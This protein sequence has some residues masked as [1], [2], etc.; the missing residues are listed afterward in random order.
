MPKE[1]SPYPSLLVGF[2]QQE[3]SGR[4]AAVGDGDLAGT[5]PCR[6]LLLAQR[7]NRKSILHTPKWPHGRGQRRSSEQM[8]PRGL[9]CLA[10]RMEAVHTCDELRRSA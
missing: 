2:A 6:H 1:G 5:A 9:R 8:A 3:A 7:L 4:V 10:L